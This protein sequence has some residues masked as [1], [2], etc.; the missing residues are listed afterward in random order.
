MLSLSF[1]AAQ[2]Q[3]IQD[4]SNPGF[5]A[6]KIQAIIFTEISYPHGPVIE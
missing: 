4:T 5:K 2:D 6:K 3:Y 1:S